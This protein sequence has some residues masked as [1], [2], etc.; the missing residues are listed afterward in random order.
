MVRKVAAG[1]AWPALAVAVLAACSSGSTSSA[2][3]GAQGVQAPFVSSASPAAAGYWTEQRL[4]AAQ[5]WQAAPVTS[6]AA[7]ASASASASAGSTPDAKQNARTLRIG[8]IFEHDSSG[9]HFCTGSVVDSPG[10]N[11]LVTAAHCING[12]RGGKNKDEIA[13]VPAYSD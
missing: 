6:E 2:A 5:E 3:Q 8:A 12:G 4:Q 11:V 9:N 1:L 10:H 7:S 13:F